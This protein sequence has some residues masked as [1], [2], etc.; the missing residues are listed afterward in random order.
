MQ[1]IRPEFHKRAWESALFH[2]NSSESDTAVE[3]GGL[4]TLEM[5]DNPFAS[6]MRRIEKMIDSGLEQD[7]RDAFDLARTAL[8]EKIFEGRQAVK[9]E[10]KLAQIIDIM[11]ADRDLGRVFTKSVLDVK[12]PAPAPALIPQ[13]APLMTLRRAA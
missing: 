10:E 6:L 8:R 4:L 13:P 11:Q 12:T 5:H 9:L 3:T 2:E 1:T 7:R